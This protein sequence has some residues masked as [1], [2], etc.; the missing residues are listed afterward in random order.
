MKNKIEEQIKTYINRPTT[1]YAVLINGEWGTGKTY[2]ITNAIDWEELCGSDKKVI[3]IS[4]N[5]L[6]SLEEIK[7]RLVYTYFISKDK[8]YAS[9]TVK[10]NN[11]MDDLVELN[12]SLGYPFAQTVS[13]LVH[14]IH[15][16][17]N[18]NKEKKFAKINHENII[19][20]LDDL[21]RLSQIIELSE[22]FGFIHDGF[23]YKGS[24]VIFIANEKEIHNEYY[25]TIKEK[26]IGHTFGF[27]PDLI[28][29]ISSIQENQNDNPYNTY[30]KEH[31]NKITAVFDVAEHI[32]I[33]TFFFFYEIYKTVYNH[34]T[35]FIENKNTMEIVFDT[36]L[37]LCIEYKKG[38]AYQIETYTKSYKFRYLSE[39][40][41][42]MDNISAQEKNA[43]DYYNYIKRTY[44]NNTTIKL[45]FMDIDDFV[46][47][48]AHGYYNADSIKEQIEADYARVLKDTNEKED[49]QLQL[50]RF[51]N[52]AYLEYAELKETIELILKYAEEGSYFENN[53]LPIYKTFQELIKFNICQNLKIEDI[54][55][56]LCTGIYE[57][58]K[59]DSRNTGILQNILP[60]KYKDRSFEEYIEHV[61]KYKLSNNKCIA[62]KKQIDEIKSFITSMNKDNDEDFWVTKQ[63][64]DD[65]YF[66]SNLSK[67][68]LLSLL[69]QLN[70]KGLNRL[71][72]IFNKISNISNAH[73]VYSSHEEHIGNILNEIKKWK[74]LE[75]DPLRIYNIVICIDAIEKAL[76]QI[77]NTI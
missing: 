61:K 23:S 14:F 12:A 15:K 76:K 69:H 22:L 28:E 10:D 18:K 65:P 34:I 52:Y 55:P 24:K 25:N 48:I 49:V 56:R 51:S 72:D 40:L 71:K 63:K 3:Y 1:D 9:N 73:E 45:R 58:L 32:N 13:S 16:K 67:F 70:N 2:F 29:I 37:I 57:R 35:T 5:G 75:T 62:E 30:I 66:F 77:R 4:L 42:N 11:L 54:V 46:N 41:Q 27:F 59:R 43:N 50:Y 68:N 74:N 17:S 47:Y 31:K 21:E 39:N 8:Q 26:Y 36:F 33:R 20:I 38:K 64:I 7:K 6:S 19:L 60:E 44:I 53:Y